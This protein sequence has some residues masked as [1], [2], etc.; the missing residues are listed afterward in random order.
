MTNPNKSPIKI[1]KNIASNKPK[2]KDS[3]DRGSK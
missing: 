2:L 3:N 1:H